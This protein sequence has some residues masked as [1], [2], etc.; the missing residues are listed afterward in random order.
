MSD[1][2]ALGHPEEQAGIDDA[3]DCQERALELACRACVGE[4]PLGCTVDDPVVRLGQD[5]LRAACAGAQHGVQAERAQA[6]H[7]R[8]ASE[9]NDL[10][11]DAAALSESADELVMAE[12]G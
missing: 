9:G 12:P 2:H 3:R 8:A 10:D 7:D 5:G 1:Q 4:R 6:A 11:R